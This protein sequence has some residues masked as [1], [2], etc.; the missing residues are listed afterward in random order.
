M[1]ADCGVCATNDCYRE[2][3]VGSR[4]LAVRMHDAEMRRHLIEISQMYE[5]LAQL[6]ERQKP[7]RH[8]C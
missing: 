8:C 1:A 3:A 5:A 4:E 7:T 2:H 6:V